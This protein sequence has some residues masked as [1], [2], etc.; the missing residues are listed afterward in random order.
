MADRLA[1]SLVNLSVLEAEDFERTPE[2]GFILTSG[3][4][5]RY[6]AEYEAHLTA[7]FKHPQTGQRTSFRKLLTLQARRLAR[8]IQEGG[9]YE[10]FW[11][12]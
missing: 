1:L 7:L 2:G 12:K 3:A 10:P 6:L 9:D 11:S 8:V 4:L 5:K